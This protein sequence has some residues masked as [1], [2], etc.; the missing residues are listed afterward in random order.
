MKEDK[1]ESLFFILISVIRID[2]CLFYHYS[3]SSS[4]FG[5]LMKKAMGAIHEACC[6]ATSCSEILEAMGKHTKQNCGIF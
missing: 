4:T 6:M 2:C 3:S 5:A 1:N